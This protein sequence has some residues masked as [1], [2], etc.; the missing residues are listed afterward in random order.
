MRTA[1][2]LFRFLVAGFL[3]L[4]PL[5]AIIAL[6]WVQRTMQR[7]AVRR[8]VRLSGEKDLTSLSSQHT[9]L[10][11]FRDSP[12]LVFPQTQLTR[13]MFLANPFRVGLESLWSNTKVGFQTVL[14]ITLFTFPIMALLLLS[15]WGGWENSFNKG[16]EQSWVG[17]TA[18]LLGIDLFILAMIY[19]PFA[20]AH[21]AASGEWRKFF[22]VRV[23][24][25]LI[26]NSPLTLVL[27]AAAFALAGI[28][29][30]ILHAGPLA[31]VGQLD[32]A[33]TG[34]LTN[35]M[36]E[37]AGQFRLAGAFVALACFM[38]VR[39]ATMRFYAD[40]LVGLI[41]SGK[42][43]VAELP[44]IQRFAFMRLGIEAPTEIPQKSLM[45]T[46][47]RVTSWIVAIPLVIALWFGFI[48]QLY[49]SQ[50]FNHYWIG[51][52]IHPIIQLPWFDPITIPP[53]P[54]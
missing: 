41:K 10:S 27:I 52:L 18:A 20:Q 40:N 19:V 33:D 16:Y 50:F 17:P 47:G 22:D 34:Q 7:R 25:A 15:W 9:N 30:A 13:S 6:G 2:V 8:W 4:T 28:P 12:K 44:T 46:L 49:I 26:R 32:G 3:C 35:V 21:Q 39:V 1:A 53:P 11:H 45:K 38:V 5:T 14:A 24:L 37:A 43:E 23:V 36:Q 29:I 48:T 42:L 31:L 51:W 54:I